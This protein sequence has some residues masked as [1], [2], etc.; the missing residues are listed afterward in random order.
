MGTKVAPLALVSVP[1]SLVA[2]QEFTL[3][4]DGGDA[5][6][7][8][9]ISLVKGSPDDL[10]NIRLITD[11]ARNGAYTWTV[12]NDLLEGSDYALK[13]SQGDFVNYTTQFSFYNVKVSSSSGFSS[14]SPATEPGATSTVFGSFISSAKSPTSMFTTDTAGASTLV[15]LSSPLLT[16]SAS[17]ITPSSSIFTSPLSSN[18]K[19]SS[20]TKTNLGLGLGLG[21]PLLLVTA[22]I[23]FYFVRRRR[24]TRHNL[25]PGHQTDESVSGS[26]IEK[27]EGT[28]VAELDVKGPL[29]ELEDKGRR[30]ELH[31]QH[32]RELPERSNSR[33]SRIKLS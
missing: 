26:Y 10:R 27:K 12:P 1:N 28:T 33:P 22:A 31:D 25:A 9:T 6:A 23:I 7:P 5:S 19:S 11:S 3:R 15:P 13:I 14:I 30:P 20:A 16:P 4:W 18:S 24:M 2:G 29:P 17:A 8:V 21:I 32:L